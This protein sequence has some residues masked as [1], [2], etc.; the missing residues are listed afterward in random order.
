[1]AKKDTN[2]TAK[3]MKMFSCEAE[4]VYMC[5][6]IAAGFPK[7]ECYIAIYKPMTSGINALVN[8]H[9]RDNP[10]LNSLITYLGAEKTEQSYSGSTDED[11]VEEMKD[12]VEQ[13][14]D[15]DF[16]IAQFHKS[17]K[18]LTGKERADILNKIAELNQLK[19]EET[20]AEEER[21]HFYL[22]LHICKDCPNKGNLTK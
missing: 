3:L 9:L 1:M 20:K 14:K 19:K 6:L 18:G 10:Q 4:D 11:S 16:M 7:S 5:S 22:P 13:Y 12:L 2:I 17:L 15:K 21:V 8:K